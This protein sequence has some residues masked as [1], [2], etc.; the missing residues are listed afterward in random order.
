MSLS[1][2]DELNRTLRVVDDGVKSVEVAEEQGCTLV[3]C[4]T[5]CETDGQ[6]VVTKTLL[7]SN[8]LARSI[9]GAELRI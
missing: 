5:P 1:G 7:D 4:E 2:E 6:H 8:H 3:G 9:V